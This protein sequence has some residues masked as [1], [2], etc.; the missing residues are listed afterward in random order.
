MKS[1]LSHLVSRLAHQGRQLKA[2]KCSIESIQS[3][4]ASTGSML[5]NLIAV[6]SER[7]ITS[8][9]PTRDNKILKFLSIRFLQPRRETG[10]VREYQETFE[11]LHSSMLREQNL[12]VTNQQ[13]SSPNEE[14]GK[15][16]S[17]H[18]LD[19]LKS[20]NNVLACVKTGNHDRFSKKVN[21]DIEKMFVDWIVYTQEDDI[22]LKDLS[23]EF[24]LDGCNNVGVDGCHDKVAYVSFLVDKCLHIPGEF[25]HYNDDKVWFDVFSGNYSCSVNPTIRGLDCIWFGVVLSVISH[26]AGRFNKDAEGHKPWSK[27]ATGFL[28]GTTAYGKIPGGVIFGHY[29]SQSDQS[30]ENYDELGIN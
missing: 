19:G 18:N 11:E 5:D 20:I 26:L 12:E 9:T 28:G 27:L 2:M 22:S 24:E 23:N 14:R 29:L 1:R 17:H 16:V 13:K 6:F 15:I 25:M 8:T 4:M 3:S 30:N 10:S 21:D 7:G